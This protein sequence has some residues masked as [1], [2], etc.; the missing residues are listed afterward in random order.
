MA[1]AYKK[2]ET[3]DLLK[4]IPIEDV[5]YFHGRKLIS[6][7][8]T[9]IVLDWIGEEEILKYIENTGLLEAIKNKLKSE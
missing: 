9:E 7:L 6:E 3:Y 2:I 4:M 5:V 8:G 1:H